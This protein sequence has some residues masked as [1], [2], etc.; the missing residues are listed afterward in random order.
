MPA[1]Q[2]AGSDSQRRSAVARGTAAALDGMSS[3]S[4]IPGV[5]TEGGAETELHA[6]AWS[7]DVEDARRLIDAGADVNYIDTAGEPPMHG[8]AACGHVEMVEFLLSQGARIN[9]QERFGL[10][11]LHWAASH[12]GLEV[13]R[14]LVEHGADTSLRNGNGKTARDVAIAYNAK[15]VADFLGALPSNKSLER[16]RE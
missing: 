7:G 14:K 9:T 13:A 3:S 4:F 12:G 11:A 10:T 1:Q 2:A 15:D 16:T 8:A 6:A 5:A